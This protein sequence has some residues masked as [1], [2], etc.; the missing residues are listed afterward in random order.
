VRLR[1]LVAV[2]FAAVAA[3]VLVVAGQA[4]VAN[5]LT[6]TF[7]IHFAKGYPASN[8]PC[9]PQGFC[10]VGTVAGYGAATITILDETFGEIPDS[11]C[12]AGTRIEEIA[13]LDATGTLVLES[14]GTFCRLGGSGDSNS[15]PVVLRRARP[16]GSPVHRRRSRLDTHRARNVSCWHRDDGRQRRRLASQWA[17]DREPIDRPAG[18]EENRGARISWI[19]LGRPAG[20]AAT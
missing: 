20:D 6:A 5:R 9:D 18:L 14:S 16:L 1:L 19:R 7:T 15:R 17:V 12:F 3:A 10:G 11:A 4:S 13:L 8:A 2:F